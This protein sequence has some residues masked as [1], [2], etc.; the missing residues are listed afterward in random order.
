MFSWN[1]L[2]PPFGVRQY[3]LPI[4]V[5]FPRCNKNI[6]Q[7]V[8]GENV[9]LSA[10]FRSGIV[11]EVVQLRTRFLLDNQWHVHNIDMN[12][13]DKLVNAKCPLSA[14][15]EVIYRNSTFQIP[16]SMNVT[17]ISIECSGHKF[18]PLFCAI[19]PVAL[20]SN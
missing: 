5:E 18:Y 1:N 7:F 19:I 9:V 20:T 14:R 15:T 11:T 10:K 13:C 16:P 3:P 6:C 17:Q 4:Y 8:A 12:G 2:G